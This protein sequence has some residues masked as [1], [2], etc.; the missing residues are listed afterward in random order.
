MK[1]SQVF[2]AT[3]CS[4]LLM[5]VAVA[6]SEVSTTTIQQTIKHKGF[7]LKDHYSFFNGEGIEY[8]L[9]RVIATVSSFTWDESKQY[10][11]AFNVERELHLER[12]SDELVSDVPAIPSSAICVALEVCAREEQVG[13]PKPRR[14]LTQL[15]AFMFDF[16]T[17]AKPS[18]V[19]LVM[20]MNE[21]N[22]LSMTATLAG[23]QGIHSY[24]I[25]ARLRL[26]S[27]TELFSH[28]NATLVTKHAATTSSSTFNQAWEEIL[29]RG[30]STY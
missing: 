11:F 3:V 20:K 16:E 27:D 9:E 13:V 10:K 21:G 28:H 15:D 26:Q 4:V 6:S 30:R 8:D 7:S 17:L 23:S 24:P 2:L 18:A 5:G 12:D 14:L 29:N 1:N 22:H 25:S 19:A